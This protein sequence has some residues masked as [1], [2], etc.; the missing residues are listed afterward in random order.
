MRAVIPLRRYLPRNFMSARRILV[1]APNNDLML[2]QSE[3]LGATETL[4]RTPGLAE[5]GR[6]LGRRPGRSGGLAMPDD[7][8]VR[9]K[10]STQAGAQALADLFEAVKNGG[11]MD[12]KAVERAGETIIRSIGE[13]GV[14]NWLETVRR[15][16]SGTYQHCLLVT[17]IAT[18][19]AEALGM[20]PE[21]V[22]DVAVAGL[23]HDVGKAMVPTEILDSANPLGARDLEMMRMHPIHGYDFVLKQPSLP[24]WVADAVRHHHEYLDGSGYPDGL[25]G[26]DIDP[27]TR[28]LTISDIFGAMV[29]KRA[30]KSPMPAEA[31]YEHLE[32]LAG[33][34]KLD[35][36]LVEAFAAVVGVAG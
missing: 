34:G 24:T 21:A 9:A 13:A 23:L 19:F 29:E 10:A 5:F 8:A 4:P 12:G 14:G 22:H 3:A 36:A 7:V 6:L 31:A 27:L 15:H 32:A 18:A 20:K 26:A 17:G 1:A 16:H 11:A 30:Y 33:K 35:A 2:R 25:S 28:A